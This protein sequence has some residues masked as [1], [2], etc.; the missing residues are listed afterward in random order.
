VA[1]PET[2][3][4]VEVARI[5]AE[6]DITIARLQSGAEKHTA[7]VYAEAEVES[8]KAEAKGLEAV[9]ADQEA[10]EH[11]A[12]AVTVMADE[13][14]PGEPADQAPAPAEPENVNVQEV[15][16]PEPPKHEEHHEV[17]AKKKS[18]LGMWS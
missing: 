10:D 6:R 2:N 9:Y 7:D 18:G 5:A 12:E 15:E 14:A 13:L 1:L 11:L 8:A 4:E 16:I 17:P 3:A